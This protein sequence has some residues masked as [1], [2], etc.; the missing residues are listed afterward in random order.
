MRSSYHYTHRLMLTLS[1]SY[2][3]G[4]QMFMLHTVMVPQYLLSSFLQE[5]AAH[6]H[7]SLCITLH[8]LL[9]RWAA[10]PPEPARLDEL[11]ELGYK[12]TYNWLRENNKID[13]SG[14]PAGS[15]ASSQTDSPRGSQSE[16]QSG[17]PNKGRSPHAGDRFFGSDAD[18][19]DASHAETEPPLWRKL[20][21]EAPSCDETLKEA[22]V[23]KL[24]MIC[25]R[26]VS[27]AV[28]AAYFWS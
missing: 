21:C 17:S 8:S 20:S 28:S 24:F 27:S 26:P 3:V 18:S 16:S 14:V 2:Q 6:H 10:Y 11:F 22:V 13:P 4:L 7:S 19:T 12:D 9:C 15:Q 1:F 5:F 25:Y 23:G